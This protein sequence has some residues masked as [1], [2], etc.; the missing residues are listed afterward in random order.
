[1]CVVHCCNRCND[2]IVPVCLFFHQSFPGTVM[3]IGTLKRNRMAIHS[4]S[5]KENMLRLLCN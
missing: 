3:R 2:D 4:T 1:M 5:V